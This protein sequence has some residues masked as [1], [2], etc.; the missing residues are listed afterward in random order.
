MKVSFKYVENGGFQSDVPDKVPITLKNSIA[1]NTENFSP[2]EHL[3]IAMGGC[4]SDDVVGILNKMKVGFRSFRCEVT[5][6]RAEEHP[7]TLT[8][9][10][11]HYILEGDV[12]PEKARKAIGLSLTKYCSVSIIVKRGGADLRYSLTINNKNIDTER[13][14]EEAVASPA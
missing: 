10:N 4:S 2:T 3:L 9:V 13:V 6:E 5:G 12:D 7:K 8:H 11:I 14:P 1:N